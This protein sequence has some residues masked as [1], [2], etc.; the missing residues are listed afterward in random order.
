MVKPLLIVILIVFND[1]MSKS[2]GQRFIT[3]EHIAMHT[4]LILLHFILQYFSD[5]AFKVEILSVTL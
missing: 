1:I 2:H 3:K 5:E 4:N